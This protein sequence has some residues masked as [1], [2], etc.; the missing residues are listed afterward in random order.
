VGEAYFA[1]TPNAV[2][3]G[4]RL[5]LEY[6]AGPLSAWFKA[7]ADFIIAWKPYYFDV[8]ISLSVGAAFTT[9]LFGATVTLKA[10]IGAALQLWGPPT[11][12]KVKIN[13]YV[14]SFVIP[15]GDQNPDLDNKPLGSWTAFSNNFLP[16]VPPAAS[17]AQLA[18][19]SSTQIANT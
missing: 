6:K 15:I 17:G 3:A 4:G 1:L 19:T 13:W 12:G 14:I 11:A 18:A 8:D 16:Q 9:K 7:N 10:E 5:E 2:M